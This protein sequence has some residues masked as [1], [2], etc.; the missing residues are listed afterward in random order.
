MATD[1]TKDFLA[2]FRFNVVIGGKQIGVASVSDIDVQFLSSG[3]TYTKPVEIVAAPGTGSKGLAGV[4][5]ERPWQRQDVIL[6]EFD[7]EGKVCRRIEMLKCKVRGYKVD[8]HDAMEVGVVIDRIKL[9]PS[10]V[11]ISTG[12]K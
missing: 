9:H 2:S 8:K 5:G 10:K 7:K 3:K 4:L 6:D 1:K 12:G 11:R